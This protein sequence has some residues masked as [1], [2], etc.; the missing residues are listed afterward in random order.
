MLKTW[1]SL[2]FCCLVNALP[3]R[4]GRPLNEWCFMPLL[5]V[6]Q[7]YHGDSSHYSCFLGWALKCLAQGHSHEK[8]PEDLVRL[9]PRTP[10][11][12]VKHLTT[13]PRGTLKPLKP[14]RGKGENVGKSS[15]FPFPTIFSNL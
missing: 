9:E 11:L 8:N 15:T 7:S 3:P 6:F 13:E 5:T 4:E 14:L 2:T 1:T 10:G 12:P